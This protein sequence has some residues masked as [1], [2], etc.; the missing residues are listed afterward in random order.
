MSLWMRLLLMSSRRHHGGGQPPPRSDGEVTF[1]AMTV[2]ATGNVSGGTAAITFDSMSAQGFGDVGGAGHLTISGIGFLLDGNAWIPRGFSDGHFELTHVGDEAGDVAMGGTGLRTVIRKY[3]TYG[4][5]FQQDMQQEGQPGDLK[6]AYLTESVRRLTA[7]RAAGMRNGVAMDSNKGQGVEA[8][9]GNDFFSGSTEGNRQWALHISTAVYLATNYGDLIDWF[10]PLVEPN[11]AVVASKEALWARQEEFMTAVLAVAPNM[12]FAIGPRDYA[13]GNIASAINPTWLDSGS[14][15]Y[16]RVFMTCNF[17]NNLS[18]NVSQRVARAALVASTRNS[19]GV[20]A[21]INQISTHPIND[22]GDIHLDATMTLLDQASGG[23]IGMDYWERVSVF[24]QQADGLYF[25]TDTA[26]PNSARDSHPARIG[27]VTAHFAGTPYWMSPPVIVG[28]PTQG[29]PVAYISGQVAGR[30]TPSV[31]SRVRVNGVDKGDAATYVIQ[32]GDVGLPVVIRR[33]ATNTNGS[34]L[35]DSAAVNAVGSG[36]ATVLDLRML[37]GQIDTPLDY[38][39]LTMYQDLAKSIRNF[40]VD[41]VGFRY[42]EA[43]TLLKVA[44]LT[45]VSNVVSVVLSEAV[46]V[47]HPEQDLASGM[48]LVLTCLQDATFDA[49]HAVITVADATHFTYPTTGQADASYTAVSE[50]DVPATVINSV[51]VGAD[52]QPTQNFCGVLSAVS[53]SATAKPDLVGTYVGTFPDDAAL[54]SGMTFDSATLTWAGGSTFTLGINSTQSGETIAMHCTGVTAGF[55]MPRIIRNDHDTSGLTL[56]R[57]DFVQFFGRFLRVLRVM[58]GGRTNSNA[59]I[60]SWAKRPVVCCGMGMTLEDMVRACNELGC[61][62]WYCFPHWASDDYVTQLSAYVR[63]HLDPALDFLPQSSN[64]EWNDRT[65][66]H[67]AWCLTRLRKLLKAHWHGNK[68]E[69]VI[70]SVTKT[71]GVVTVNMNRAPPFP[72]GTTVVFAI[73]AGTTTGYNT[74]DTGAVATVAGNSFSF[75]GNSGSGTATCTEATIIGNPTHQLYAWD[76]VKTY[77]ELATRMHGQR[78]YEIGQLVSAVFGGLNGRAKVLMMNWFANTVPNGN[79]EDM[80]LK[81]LQAQYGSTRAWLWGLGGA[82]YPL[83]EAS[84]TTPAQVMASLRTGHD[85]ALDTY[86]TQFHRSSYIAHRYAHEHIQY[87]G[88]PDL[89]ALGSNTA[90]VDAVYADADYRTFNAELVRRSLASGVDVYVP[91]YTSMAF[92]G[93]KGAQCWGIA[94]TLAADKVIGSASTTRIRG[95]DDVLL[96]A[97]PAYTDPNKLPG[98]LYFVGGPG[99]IDDTSGTGLVNGMRQLFS[100]TAQCEDLFFVDQAD[101]GKNVVLTIWGGI[102]VGGGANGVRVYLDDAFVG[103]CNLQTT[104]HLTDML[105]GGAASP[106]TITLPAVAAGKHRLKIMA[107]TPQPSEVGVSR[108]D[109]V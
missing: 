101:G 26:D 9:G 54:P 91:F 72:N 66:P 98:T 52:G 63:D 7:S 76:K 96:A 78:T 106:G 31:T 86:D 79:L 5:G 50:Y 57:P 75:S 30:P 15:F 12:L 23:A 33:T 22:P 4:T 100:S 82:P 94:R 41:S 58:D 71:A 68:G 19:Q 35:S 45:R 74:S 84:N 65:F 97:P 1:D 39:G 93:T 37:G 44:S 89:T 99:F 81:Y 8:S 77:R 60:K 62:F 49:D 85:D 14:P 69:S 27:V 36:A 103:T 107:P 2:A 55:Q 104:T 109:G 87:E 11:S 73:T 59:W 28:T 17:L 61:D 29:S 13:A 47:E 48:R 10:E 40:A 38:S 95:I 105:S 25:L 43:T 16:R 21:W 6:P 70:T 24:S 64:E 108:V 67:L 32:A 34:T 88:G 42:Q 46:T 51:A 56:L 83:A 90:L 80:A 20:P 3:G 102:L 53:G 18:T 92:T